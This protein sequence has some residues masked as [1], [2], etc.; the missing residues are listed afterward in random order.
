M[1]KNKIIWTNEDID[2]DYYYAIENKPYL[3]NSQRY[4]M[5]VDCSKI[6]KTGYKYAIPSI[7]TDY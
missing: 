4:N 2:Y 1:K 5:K 7:W 3:P 6:L